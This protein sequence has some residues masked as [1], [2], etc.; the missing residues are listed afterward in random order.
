MAT[1]FVLTIKIYAS[2]LL[3]DAMHLQR[4][5]EDNLAGEGEELTD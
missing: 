3:K 4:N 5:I 2:V 1:L